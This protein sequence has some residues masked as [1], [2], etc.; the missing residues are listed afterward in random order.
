[1][2]F[3][4]SL[5]FIWFSIFST[6]LTPYCY[7]WSA[8]KPLWQSMLARCVSLTC[9]SHS[10]GVQKAGIVIPM[11]G[12]THIFVWSPCSVGMHFVVFSTPLRWYLSKTS[13]SENFQMI[14]WLLTF[15]PMSGRC[16]FY[17]F[18]DY[19]QTCASHPAWGSHFGFGFS[20]TPFEALTRLTRVQPN[21]FSRQ[22]GYF[23]RR[24]SHAYEVAWRHRA[25]I[26]DW[27][28]PKREWVKCIPG[29]PIVTSPP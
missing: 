18:S 1:M 27:E 14:H 7:F 5:Y 8:K 24:E 11:L 28:N 15:F 2:V 6:P 25:G 26:G 19:L 17:V 22:V 3:K 10:G 21:G 23:R 16:M 12:G 29:L 9:H 4:I 13:I 20:I